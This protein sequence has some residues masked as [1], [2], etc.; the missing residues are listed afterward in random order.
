MTEDPVNTHK[1]IEILPRTAQFKASAS[2]KPNVSEFPADRDSRSTDRPSQPIP[3]PGPGGGGDL[4]EAVQFSRG[5]VLTGAGDSSAERV[6]FAHRREPKGLEWSLL[7]GVRAGGEAVTCK[8][9]VLPK[10]TP[11]EVQ[12]SA[13]LFLRLWGQRRQ[14]LP[15]TENRPKQSGHPAAAP[16][17]HQGAA[18]TAAA[19]AARTPLPLSSGEK[20][21]R[22]L[23][24][25]PGVPWRY[26]G[27][28]EAESE[29][30]SGI[31]TLQSL[32]S[33]S[34]SWYDMM[35]VKQSSTSTLLKVEHF[36][37]IVRVQ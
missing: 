19:P 22:T 35:F 14:T 2:A 17:H 20:P 6:G 25:Q 32:L 13:G 26:C 28:Q 12:G 4:V 18:G 8:K 30:Q 7:P 3:D 33:N 11:G 21:L 23:R 16:Q 34:I 31:S 37:K 5:F 27:I 9:P 10:V 15:A 24:G 29:T 36:C 1:D